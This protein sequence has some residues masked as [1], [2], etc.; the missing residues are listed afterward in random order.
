M[1]SLNQAAHAASNTADNHPDELSHYPIIHHQPF[2]G[3]R[4][5]RLTI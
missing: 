5:M 4:W 2:T 1:E 3:A